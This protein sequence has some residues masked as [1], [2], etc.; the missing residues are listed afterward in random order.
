MHARI[1]VRMHQEFYLTLN[2]INILC[3]EYSN[4]CAKKL[5]FKSIKVH[6]RTLESILLMLKKKKK[7]KKHKISGEFEIK[8]NR[9]IQTKNNYI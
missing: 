6:L 9:P 1:F 2:K 3:A 7:K 4:F 8:K 5:Y